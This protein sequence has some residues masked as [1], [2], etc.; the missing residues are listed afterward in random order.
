MWDTIIVEMGEGMFRIIDGD[1]FS[2]TIGMLMKSKRGFDKAYLNMTETEKRQNI[3]RP[4]L[5]V[6]K[7]GLR[8]ILKMEFSAPNI[9][10]KNNVD[11]MT[12]QDFIPM[13]NSIQVFLAGIV[14]VS[15]TALQNASVTAAHASKNIVLRSGYGAQAVIAELYKVN[16]G[17]W[18]DLDKVDFRNNGRALQ[19]RVTSN[20]LVLYDKIADYKQSAKRSIDKTSVYQKS[21]FEG[22]GQMDEQILRIEARLTNKKKMNEVLRVVG[23]K[24]NPTLK[25]LFESEVLA[26]NIINNYLERFFN[27]GSLFVLDAECNPLRV[28]KKL[29][30]LK[31][32]TTINQRLAQ[33]GL[34][35][36]CRDEEGIRGLR[37]VLP[38]GSWR[39]I[40]RKISVFDNEAFR[41]VPYDFIREIK[42]Q[43]SNYKAVRLDNVQGLSC[44]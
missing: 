32:P 11:E 39:A 16:Y 44:K 15:A 43:I 7:R 4:R 17:R 27:K 3:Y 25:D 36:L 19:I 26:M 12:I 38:V 14:A 1:R 10:Y 23:G 35:V 37:E 33:V 40:R 21:L 13:V 22:I 28:Y 5:T 29:G 30:A 41:Q 9:V 42:A 34:Y 2:P 6:L 18:F 24:V 20:S 31:R 8:M